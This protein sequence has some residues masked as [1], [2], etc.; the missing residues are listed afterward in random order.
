MDANEKDLKQTVSEE[1]LENVTGGVGQ[2]ENVP[3]VEEHAY[4][5]PTVI[6]TGSGKD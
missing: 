4:D 2:F 5:I 1:K 6:V 3:A